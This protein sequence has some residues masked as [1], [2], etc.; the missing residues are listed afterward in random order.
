MG[1]FTFS[2]FVQRALWDKRGLWALSGAAFYFG[3]CWDKAGMDK[4]EMMKGQSKMFASRHVAVPND[5][6]AWK[7]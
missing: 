5:K 4:A 7:Y 1:T 2:Y 3:H 6:D